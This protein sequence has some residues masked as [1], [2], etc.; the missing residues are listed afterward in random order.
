M[1]EQCVL[2]SEQITGMARDLGRVESKV[3][4]VSDKIDSFLEMSRDHADDIELLKIFKS[5]T[6]L[7]ATVLGAVGGIL[8]TLFCGGLT[9][10][11]PKG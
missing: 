3:D 2:H 5:N 10:L 6:L 7:I 11:I 8:T 4:I 9:F 1:N